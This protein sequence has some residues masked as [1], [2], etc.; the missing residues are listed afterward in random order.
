MKIHHFESDF[1]AIKDEW[2]WLKGQNEYFV[3]KHSL[4]V[5]YCVMIDPDFESLT[6]KQQNI[7]KWAALLHDNKK[8]SYPEINSKD[9]IHP[10]RS[11]VVFLSIVQKIKFITPDNI[12]EFEKG[13]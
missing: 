2:K 7:L 5:V 4:V 11:A 12:S 6:P 1:E 10:F 9:W 13:K 3:C 8:R